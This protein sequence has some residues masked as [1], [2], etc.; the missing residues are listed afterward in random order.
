MTRATGES[1]FI[2][3]LDVLLGFTS[4][5]TVFAAAPFI[6]EATAWGCNTTAGGTGVWKL[7]PETLCLRQ[8]QSLEVP[9]EH[10]T[11][12]DPCR[13]PL[14]VCSVYPTPWDLAPPIPLL[15]RS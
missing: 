6:Q 5:D 8:A 2:V 9:G 4:V 15:Q 10:R 3:G 11:E 14:K 13:H 12:S 1:S 7:L